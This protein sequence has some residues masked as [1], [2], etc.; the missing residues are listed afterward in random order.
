MSD[1]PERVEGVEFT[2]I[3]PVL[4]DIDYP[5]TA[6]QFVNQYGHYEIERTN[7]GPITIR[8]LFEPLEE[9][10]FESAKEVRETIMSLMPKE[11]VGRQRYSDR[12]STIDGPGQEDREDRPLPGHE[13]GEGLDQD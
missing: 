10:Q 4:D 11:S 8:E 3:N 2:S 7:A 6:D 9:D 1:D 13:E 12:G 5:I